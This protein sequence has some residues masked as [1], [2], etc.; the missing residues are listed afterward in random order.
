MTHIKYLKMAP[1]QNGGL[2]TLRLFTSEDG[3]R[4]LC[5]SSVG[6]ISGNLKI[7]DCLHLGRSPPYQLKGR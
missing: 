6:N 5:P 2:F 3:V 1:I 4:F 7:A